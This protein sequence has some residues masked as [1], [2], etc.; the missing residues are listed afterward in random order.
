M[1]KFALALTTVLALGGLSAC[2]GDSEYCS[3]LKGADKEIGNALS[4][5]DKLVPVYEKIAEKAPAS[6]K[7]DWNTVVDGMKA[8]T[9][10]DVENYDADKVMDA[11]KNISKD[12][13]DSCNV[14][15]PVG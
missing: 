5:P 15:M 12:A 2:G 14:K 13:E 8:A 7:D 6:V 11:L 9:S 4:S 1:K 10:G 3:T